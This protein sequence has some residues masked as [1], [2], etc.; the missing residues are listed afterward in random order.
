MGNKGF[1][2]PPAFAYAPA[3]ACAHAGCRYRRAFGTL[4]ASARCQFAQRHVD[5]LKHKE[6][7]AAFLGILSATY[8]NMVHR[9]GE[10]Y[11]RSCVASSSLQR[12]AKI[13]R[14][15]VMLIRAL[16]AVNPDG[17]I[18]LLKRYPAYKALLHAQGPMLCAEVWRRVA[19]NGGRLKHRCEI[20]AVFALAR[21]LVP[22]ATMMCLL[23]ETFSVRHNAMLTLNYWNGDF[24][25]SDF[26][27]H[28]L[29][30]FTPQL[31]ATLMPAVAHD[32]DEKDGGS[33]ED[34]LIQLCEAACLANAENFKIFI[35]IQTW[36]SSPQDVRPTF[37]I[38]LPPA[39]RRRIYMSAVRSTSLLPRGARLLSEFQDDEEIVLA[40]LSLHGSSTL[41][42]ASER[43]R[44]LKHVALAAVSRFG[45]PYEHVGE[46]MKRDRD[47]C[48]AAFR[49]FGMALQYAPD[50]IR[51][52]AELVL[53]AVLQSKGG[54][55]SQASERLQNDNDMVRT[56]LSMDGRSIASASSRFRTD[57][58]AAS[59]A[60][61]NNPWSL[62]NLKE[63]QALRPEL[64]VRLACKAVRSEWRIVDFLPQEIFLE[65]TT[66][67][68]AEEERTSRPRSDSVS[69]AKRL[70]ASACSGWRNCRPGEPGALTADMKHSFIVAQCY[71]G[72]Y[73]GMKPQRKLPVHLLKIILGFAEQRVPV[74]TNPT[75]VMRKLNEMLNDAAKKCDEAGEGLILPLPHCGA[76]DFDVDCLEV[77]TAAD[78]RALSLFS[79]SLFDNSRESKAYVCCQGFRDEVMSAIV[80]A[81]GSADRPPGASEAPVDPELRRLHYDLARYERRIDLYEREDVDPRVRDIALSCVSRCPEMME[82]L[83]HSTLRHDP[84]IVAAAKAGSHAKARGI[85][86]D[87]K[88]ARKRKMAYD[89]VISTE[90]RYVADITALCDCFVRPLRME[91]AQAQAAGREPLLSPQE[92]AE[93]FGAIEQLLV[94]NTKLLSDMTGSSVLGGDDAK[95]PISLGPL[96]IEFSPYLKMYSLFA[97]AYT[98]AATT[99]AELKVEREGF[100]AWLEIA[101]KD[102]R[103]RGLQITD[104]LIMPVQRVPRYRMLLAELIKHTDETDPTHDSLTKALDGIKDTATTINNYIAAAEERMKIIKIQSE[105]FGDNVWLAKAGRRLIMDENLTKVCR[106][107]NKEYHFF[108]FTDAVMYASERTVVTGA[109][110]GGTHKFHREIDLKTARLLSAPAK[111]GENAFCIQSPKKSFFVITPDAETKKRWCAGIEK[112]IRALAAV[113]GDGGVTTRDKKMAPVW[114]PDDEANHC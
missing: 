73:D 24:H 37:V 5:G 21:T 78:P 25:N 10:D 52:D 107:R 94:L 93:I 87:G 64:F 4:P 29:E 100:S 98:T 20:E 110:V 66:E 11:L 6:D 90:R 45:S 50:M 85:M 42:T 112:S 68:H 36:G 13:T 27:F 89:E 1:G 46:K 74:D 60:V 114:Q 41:Q 91:A 75:R 47:V 18:R 105:M 84:D 48:R 26:F 51:D 43:V 3:C 39:T 32:G 95:G 76:L 108:L 80:S 72:R 92:H 49:R 111:I 71:R 7:K 8:W 56:A 17:A 22:A 77:A 62:E 30:L 99:L 70:F 81:G 19:Q 35:G 106:S 16:C 31:R 103:C 83:R 40:A 63:L 88:R 57:P 96:F 53:M 28:C 58:I 12:K 33:E 15:V 65:A 113:G 82:H 102:T 9:D 109:L 104:L 79:R 34:P 97:S 69:I 54:A 86:A 59:I 44:N 55:L 23:R 14:D 67:C 2:T 101:E 38:D 61:D